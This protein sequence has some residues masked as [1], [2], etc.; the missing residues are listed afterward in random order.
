MGASNLLLQDTVG[1]KWCLE[2]PSLSDCQATKKHEECPGGTGTSHWVRHVELE[3]DFRN[4]AAKQ[5]LI[6]ETYLKK[7]ETRP[8]HP[9]LLDPG[10]G[11]RDL[12]VPLIEA[13]SRSTL[14]SGEEGSV[15]AARPPSS[16]C[17]RLLRFV[18]HK[19]MVAVEAVAGILEEGSCEVQWDSEE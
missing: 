7:Q 18:H 6:D 14:D 19:Q 1:M 11:N 3:A 8:L 16:S 4:M 17:F 10:S 2:L 12:L 13:M 9:R 5:L 15:C